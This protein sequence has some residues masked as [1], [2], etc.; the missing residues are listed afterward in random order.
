MALTTRACSACDRAS[1]PSVR[2]CARR[3]GATR[4]RKPAREIG[5]HLVVRADVDL[6]VEADVGCC[7]GVRGRR[8]H[9]CGH[10]LLQVLQP[11]AF[12]GRHAH[13]RQPRAG[14]LNLRHRAEQ[15]FELG[16]R[17]PR[18]RGAAPGLDVDEAGGASR[19]K[20]RAPAFG[21]P[22]SARPA[23]PRR[24]EARAGIPPTA[25]VRDCVGKPIRLGRSVVQLASKSWIQP[26]S[27]NFGRRSMN[28]QH[29]KQSLGMQFMQLRIHDCRAH[30]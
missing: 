27:P 19:A 22:R 4:R 21:R 12:D 15:R 7:I 14:R 2:N 16:G 1:R 17:R 11:A 18:D 5:Q 6:G 30:T 3:N 8:G 29:A 9:E 10:R 24:A 25:R 20:P 13:R 26:V 28:Y 23:C